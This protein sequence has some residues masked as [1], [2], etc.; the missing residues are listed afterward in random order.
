MDEQI[1]SIFGVSTLRFQHGSNT[2]GHALNE[3][4][5]RLLWDIHPLVL[6]TPPQL[7]DVGRRGFGFGEPLL[8]AGLQM[9]NRIQIWRLRW[10]FQHANLVALEPLMGDTG[11]V[12]GS[13]S[14]WKTISSFSS[15]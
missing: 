15:P 12:L 14:C 1:Y 6:Y 2:P 11:G 9:L 5:A 13:L 4:D 8:E 3:I 7:I 10:P